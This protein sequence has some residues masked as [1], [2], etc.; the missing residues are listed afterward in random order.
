MNLAFGLDVDVRCVM[1]GA[2]RD[3]PERAERVLEADVVYAD[4]GEPCQCGATRVRVAVKI[5]AACGE[6]EASNA[7]RR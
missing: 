7:S 3:F 4:V 6:E 5:D 2:A 1:C